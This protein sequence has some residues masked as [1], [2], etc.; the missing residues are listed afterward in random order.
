[1]TSVGSQLTELRTVSDQ[2]LHADME[3]KRLRQ[4]MYE[5]VR[6]LYDDGRVRPVDIA[7]AA[8]ITKQR[9]NQLIAAERS[10]RGREVVR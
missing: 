10:R 7:E 6:E 1:M 4:R 2:L 3:A 8:G 5:L 9:V